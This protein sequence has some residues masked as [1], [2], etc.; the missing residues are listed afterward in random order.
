MNPDSVRPMKQ[1]ITQREIAQRAQVSELY[2][3]FIL[4]G[5]RE[6]LSV[7][8]AKRLSKVSMDLGLPFTP[9]DWMFRAREIRAHLKKGSTTDTIKVLETHFTKEPLPTER[10]RPQTP[11]EQGISDADKYD[12]GKRYFDSSGLNIH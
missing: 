1:K 4:T 7:N 3:S 5:K 11:L 6:N 12:L 8:L 9:D 10:I 2:L